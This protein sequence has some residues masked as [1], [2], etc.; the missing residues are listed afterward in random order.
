ML[1]V[2]G[3]LST[4]GYDRG[5]SDRTLIRRIVADTGIERLRP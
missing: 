1:G 2:F 5:Y 3:G 4:E